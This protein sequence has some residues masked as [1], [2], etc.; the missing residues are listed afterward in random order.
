MIRHRPGQS[1]CVLLVLAVTLALAG[2]VAAQKPAPAA[3]P[4]AAPPAPV[5]M[6]AVPLQIAAGDL[7]EV[8][9]FDSPEL[10]Q[11][12]RVGADGRAQL[13]LLGS[14]QLGGLTAQEAGDL[15]ASELRDRH[16]LLHPQVNVLIEFAS[17]GVSVTGEVQHPGVYQ[18]LGPRTLLDVLSL[19]GGLTNSADTH[20]ITIKRRSGAQETVTAKLNNNDAQ[21]SVAN[22]VQVFPG[23]LVVVPHAGVVYVLGDVNRPGG[24]IMQDSGKITLLQALAQAGGVSRSGSA[25]KAVLLRKSATGSYDTTKLRL[26]KISRGEG[27]DLELRAN[28]IVFV[29]NSGI[30]NVLR[31]TQGVIQSVGGAAVY[32]GVP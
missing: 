20:K 8:S 25:N 22:D 2:P 32:A 28:D 23:D 19:A 13:A 21:S 17:K 12:V 5:K 4:P 7:L 1:V 24:F 15:I 3:A 11:Q 18:V 30:K 31:T 10:A 26:G 29:P 14:T 6:V 16:F 27:A 9:V